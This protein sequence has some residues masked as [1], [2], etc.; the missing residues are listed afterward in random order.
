[1]FGGLAGL[2]EYLEDPSITKIDVLGENIELKIVSK[3]LVK[4]K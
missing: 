3:N 1:M 4:G 2:T